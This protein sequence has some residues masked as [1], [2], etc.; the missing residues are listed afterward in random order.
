MQAVED[1]FWCK[2]QKTDACWEWLGALRGGYGLFWLNGRQNGAHRVSYELSVGKIPEGLVLDHLCRNRACVNPGHLEPVTPH[3]NLLR[4]I[5]FAA[6]NAE[7]THCP[8]GHEYTPEN[9]YRYS[10]GGR[11]Q[12][13]TC[14]KIA[15]RARNKTDRGQAADRTHC[16]RGHE[17]TEANTY[18]S[19]SSG[20]I[21]RQCNT[22]RAR[23]GRQGH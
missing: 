10:K 5:S 6:K 11:R 13:R 19:A 2:V 18:R 23:A 7:V 15:S 14:M 22:D 4:G 12:C 1:R 16:P 21:C 20:R 8:K 9:T 3:E 17:Y